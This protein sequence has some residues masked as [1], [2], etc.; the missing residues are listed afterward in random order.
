MADQCRITNDS[1]R[2]ADAFSVLHLLH[3]H[4]DSSESE[5]IF[6][7]SSQHQSILKV[8][9]RT[10]TDSW[11]EQGLYTQWQFDRAMRARGLYFALGT[12]SL[13]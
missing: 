5:W 13:N 10:V 8:I 1:E 7:F 3:K 6:M 12:P 9:T 4:V 2:D 11:W